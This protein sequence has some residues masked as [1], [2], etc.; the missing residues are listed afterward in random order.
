M[1]RPGHLHH[2]TSSRNSMHIE[3]LYGLHESFTYIYNSYSPYVTII[4][5]LDKNILFS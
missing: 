5:F 1:C 4:R 2:L 3:F